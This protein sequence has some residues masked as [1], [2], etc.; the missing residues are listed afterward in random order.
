M[1]HLARRLLRLLTSLSPL[2]SEEQMRGLFLDAVNGALDGATLRYVPGGRGLDLVVGGEVLGA[3]EVVGRPAS[4]ESVELLGDAVKALGHSM[5][6]RR[7]DHA[8][9]A[10]QRRAEARHRLLAETAP[11]GLVETD[12]AGQCTYV[13]QQWCEITGYLPEQALGSLWV[14]A[15]HPSDRAMVVERWNECVAVEAAIDERFRFLRPDGEVRH[16]WVIVRPEY[17][18]DG[19]L[20]GY[21]CA[22]TDITPLR[23][24]EGALARNEARLSATL[25]AVE[26][27]VIEY[28]RKT[29]ETYFSPRFYQL[30]G[31]EPGAFQPTKAS[32]W[33]LLHPDDVESGLAAL[34]NGYLAETPFSVECRMHHRS[35]AWRW[36][37][38]RGRVLTR[39]AAGEAVRILSTVLDFTSQREADDEYRLILRTC[40]DGF[41]AVGRDLRILDA[42]D[43]FCQLTGYRRDELLQ[44]RL[45]DLHLWESPQA[46]RLRTA[47]IEELGWQRFESGCHHKNG[48]L[49]ALELNVTWSPSGG[50]RYIAFVRDLTE[51]NRILQQLR[52]S[53]NQ[54]RALVDN[55]AG[56]VFTASLDGTVVYASPQTE[57]LFGCPPSAWVGRRF[58]D[59][60]EAPYQGEILK[61]WNRLLA[62]ETPEPVEAEFRCSANCERRWVEVSLAV[63]RDEDGAAVAGLGTIWNLTERKAAEELLQRSEEQF[64]SVWESSADG[65][66]LADGEGTI[67]RVNSAFCRMF[68]RNRE[69]TEGRPLKECYGLSAGQRIQDSYCSKY[70][71][72]IER[73]FEASVELSNGAQVWLEV[74]NSL[75]P[76]PGGPVVLSIFRD[77]TERKATEEQLS[78]LVRAIEQ[79]PASVVVTDTQG[80]IEYVNPKFT[81]L[82]GYSAEE[83]FGQN[84]RILKSTLNQAAV[85]SELWGALT[86]GREWQGELLNRRK[87]GSLFWEQASISPVKNLSGKV[88]HFVAVKED[89]TERKRVRQELE[90]SE[91]RFR[92]MLEHVAL[93]AVQLDSEGRVTFCNDYFCSITGWTREQLMGKDCFELLIP[94]SI[95]PALRKGLEPHQENEILTADGRRLLIAWDNTPLR[96]PSGELAG[97]ASIGRDITSQRVLE[98]QYRQAQK[99]ES[100]GRLAGGVAHDF[101]NLLTVI[102]GYSEMM[103]DQ[104]HPLD[105]MHVKTR[106][107][108]RAGLRATELTRQLLAFSRKQVIEW[109]VVQLN[110]L[111]G[112]IKR[113]LQRLIGEHIS[114]ELHTDAALGPVEADPSQIHQVLMNLVVNARDA[115]PRGGVLRIETAPLCVPES[116]SSDWDLPPGAYAQLIVSDTGTGMDE[117]TQKHAFE[118]F[119]TTKGVD[120]G[121]GLGLATVY[122]IVKQHG[123]GI[124]FES[125]PGEGTRFRIALPV[126]AG[127]PVDAA[128]AA[129]HP[130]RGTESIL[131]VEDQ[132][133][134]RRLAATI[135]RTF[136]Y[137]VHEASDGIEAL[138]LAKDLQFDLLLSDMVMPNMSGY[139]LA[140]ELLRQRPGMRVVFMSGYAEQEE[141]ESP[142]RLGASFIAKPFSPQALAARIRQ[143]LDT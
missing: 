51:R 86:S 106:E 34:H 61:Y 80:R 40:F 27:A 35:G 98:E 12:S 134:V 65:M 1:N 130:E 22:V 107:I 31:H 138:K 67:L 142:E 115:M 114:L 33:G 109:K 37:R 50:G 133:E 41:L 16:V 126:C 49:V 72:G 96:G 112:E 3:F 117:E 73:I 63:Q 75:I 13:N 54:H 87:D 8:L 97:T 6:S 119:F 90:E 42:N 70:P 46:L 66:R 7:Q 26:E 23:Q 25:D 10:G 62:G 55:Q 85:Y 127:R 48:A 100:L 105:P 121:T 32:F 29:G 21:A 103:L 57:K 101:N 95:R 53:E 140:E 76:R 136:G 69:Q 77:I 15:V 30:L 129:S 139:D 99:L 92:E 28:N 118:P 89:I 123:G 17:A 71:D 56:V 14:Q 59:M 125:W 137:T 102:N 84:P 11:V 18:A 2:D 68:G 9:R 111:L 64:R 20:G 43:S 88:T 120:K 128:G 141:D 52:A 122:G 135:L 36:M 19:T 91:R 5:E 44:F 113:M 110:D 143:V 131:L 47:A 79:S 94:E 83:A 93:L 58:F 132:V 74:S 4:A 116:G 38:F 104:F 39:D 81:A 82:T 78:V 124:Q 60:V 45:S 24:A 108:L